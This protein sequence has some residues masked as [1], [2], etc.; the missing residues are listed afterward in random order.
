MKHR[1]RCVKGPKIDDHNFPWS[2]KAGKKAP[3]VRHNI[4]LNSCGPLKGQR[5]EALPP[6]IAEVRGTFPKAVK[7]MAKT[8]ALL[9][10]PDETDYRGE[11]II[12]EKSQPAL[13]YQSIISPNSS[14]NLTTHSRWN[15][16]AIALSERESYFARTR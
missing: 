10:F 5:G 11:W 6:I 3:V 7:V 15:F 1:L 16:S 12:P 8:Q 4:A 14:P 2:T 9:R 13:V